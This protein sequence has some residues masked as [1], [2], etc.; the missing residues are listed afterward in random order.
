MMRTDS[1]T[2]LLMDIKT[3]AVHDGPGIRTTFFL[4]GCPLRCVWCH[5]PE[6]IGARPQLAYYAHKCAGCGECARICLAGAHVLEASG[7]HV[8][9][10][11]RCTACGACVR[12]C[13]VEAMTLYGR[14]VTV[15][16]AVNIARK[17]RVFYEQSGGGVTVSGG[18]PLSQ[19]GFVE[20]LLRAL[21]EDGLHTAVDTCGAVPWE[22]FER[23]LPETNLFLF[24]V[25]HPDPSRHRELT[26]MDN[27]LV[28]DN[29]RRLSATGAAVELRMPLIPGTNDGEDTLREMAALLRGITYSRLKLLPY[30]A[31]ARG[32]YAA[33][34]MEDTL[35]RV[36]SPTDA[37]LDAVA[38]L[39]Q[40]GGV[41]A[42]SG[43]R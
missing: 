1:P 16:E 43:R 2:G 33:L 21:R 17:D 32:K 11:E 35:P 14:R 25:K 18:E 42:V 13:P 27:A 3:F 24:D 31:M 10:R 37:R 34:G 39:L 5:N 22:A 30:H 38:A 15:E 9:R 29:L 12:L 19:A 28:W 4:K 40:Q 8:F 41:N 26:G 7:A 20:A 23:V 36:D 6:G